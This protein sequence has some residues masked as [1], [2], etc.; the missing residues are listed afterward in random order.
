MFEDFHAHGKRGALGGAEGQV[1]AK[2][3]EHD[4]AFIA[5]KDQSGSVEE[6]GEVASR[7]D[8]V[9]DPHEDKRIEKSK[10]ASRGQAEKAGQMPGKEVP[11]PL[12]EPQQFGWKKMAHGFR[13]TGSSLLRRAKVD[14]LPGLVPEKRATVR[15]SDMRE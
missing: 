2:A 11:D 5:Q 10:G 1:A 3:G 7:Q 9:D 13:V 15:N 8:T 12:I 4:A 6:E 14:G